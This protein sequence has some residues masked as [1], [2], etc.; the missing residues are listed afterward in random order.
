MST[1][2][3]QNAHLLSVASPVMRE[4]YFVGKVDNALK[5]LRSRKPIRCR[6]LIT[7]LSSLDFD[8]RAGKGGHKIFKHQ[9]IKGLSGSFNCGHNEGDEIKPPYIRDIRNYLEDFENSLKEYLEKK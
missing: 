6:E 7:L 1:L 3:Y 2:H 9:G 4:V 5:I 8:I